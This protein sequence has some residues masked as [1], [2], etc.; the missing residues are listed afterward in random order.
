MMLDNDE[1]C[2]LFYRCLCFDIIELFYQSKLC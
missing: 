1:N 2:N